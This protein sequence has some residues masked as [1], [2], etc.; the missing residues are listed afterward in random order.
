MHHTARGW[1]CRIVYAIILIS[2]QPT[3]TGASAAGGSLL[4]KPE[5]PVWSGRRLV[6]NSG[7]LVDSVHPLFLPSE[8][9][10]SPSFLDKADHLICQTLC[11]E[12]QNPISPP[13]KKEYYLYNT[14]IVKVLTD[15]FMLIFSI[16]VW[17]INSKKKNVTQPP[18]TKNSP[19][20]E[21]KIE[22]LV[23]Q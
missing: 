13:P 4:T 3:A 17:K 5:R 16:V 2:S 22:P 6:M 10:N 7:L 19:N 12:I 14:F 8:A 20:S 9:E 1:K 21:A 11:S 18:N 15:S 23:D